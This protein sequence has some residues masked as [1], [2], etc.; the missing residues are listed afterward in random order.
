MKK[1]A[2]AT[3]VLVA[4][5]GAQ[6]QTYGEIGYA[7]I[8]AKGEDAGSSVKSSPVAVRG[9]WGHELNPNLAVE[10]MVAFGVSDA[11]VKVNGGSVTGEKMKISNAV[12]IYIKPKTK[13]KDSLEIF[14]RAGYARVN[15]TTSAVGLGSESSFSYGAGM[16]YAISP[17]T[18]LT[19]DY[20]QYL[21]KDGQKV[22]GVT[23]GIGIMF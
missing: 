8:T 18:A 7:S 4:T 10:G 11:A 15:G 6:A 14:A 22:N 3:A 17:K 20:M 23:F 12:G 13:L 5:V 9:I 16:S 19:V 21:N 1:L 2:I